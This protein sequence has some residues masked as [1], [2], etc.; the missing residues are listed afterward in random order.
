MNT[1]A[2]NKN[3]FLHKKLTY[4][5][6]FWKCQ[7]SFVCSHITLNATENIANANKNIL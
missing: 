6:E 1:V 4:C 5:S 2:S 3:I 7:S